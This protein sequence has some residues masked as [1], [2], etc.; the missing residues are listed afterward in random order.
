MQLVRRTASVL[1]IVLSGCLC[2]LEHARAGYPDRQ[3]TFVVGAG[4]G[5]LND[6]V[7]RLY[8]EHMAQILGQPIVVK[9]VPGAG[10]TKAVSEVIKANPDGYT[11]LVNGSPHSVIAA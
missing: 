9:D 8:A 1:A 11:V 5:G 2:S 4:A 10:T 6:I 3:I 7:T